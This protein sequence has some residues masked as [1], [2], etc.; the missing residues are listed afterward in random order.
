M[1]DFTN[2]PR[3]MRRGLLLAGAS[4]PLLGAC[5]VWPGSS[6]GQTQADSQFRALE[7]SLDGRLGVFAIDTGSGR[8]LSWRGAERFPACSTFKVVLCG[9]ILDRST[10]EPGLLTQRV[11]YTAADLVSYS[12]ITEKHLQDGMKVAEL[13]AAAIRYSDNT[14][15]NLL[16][17]LLGGPAA[18]TAY[19]RASGD[20]VFRLDRWETDL[21]EALPG[22]PRDTTTPQA[23]AGM[24]QRLG[25]GS[26]LPAQQ[27][28]QL[29]DWLK[30]NTTG[31][32][33]IR[34]GLPTDWQVG[35]KTGTGSY[36]TG[37]DVA[38]VWPPQRA[39]L[40]IAVFTTRSQK[41]AEARS[42][43]LAGA[44]RIVAANFA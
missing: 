8:E 5:S 41:D 33:R 26:L 29:Q 15:A 27:R 39:P 42:D 17:K 43:V 13:C 40:V 7:A 24:L 36:G 44:A 6:Q 4:L 11:R 28:T 1:P 23:M 30:G 16:M 37:N 22:D 18:V 34:A 3:N 2:R 20:D 31:A 25:L 32:T 35:D 38:L 19:A 9:A 12:P 10:R 21:N 14:A